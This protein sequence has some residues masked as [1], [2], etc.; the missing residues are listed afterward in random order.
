MNNEELIAKI[1]KENYELKEENIL[2]KES[3]NHIKS[4]LVCIGGPLND[5]VLQFNKEQR[6]YLHKILDII[7]SCDLNYCEVC[8]G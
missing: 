2:F 5:N 8:D 1:T 3:L 4:L 7:E 6:N